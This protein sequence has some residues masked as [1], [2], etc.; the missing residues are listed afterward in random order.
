MSEPFGRFMAG[1]FAGKAALSLVRIARA[2][3][4]VFL[5]AAAALVVGPVRQARA[6]CGDYLLSHGSAQELIAK[7]HFPLEPIE[8]PCYGPSCSGREAPP[9]SAAPV[10]IRANTQDSLVA[11]TSRDVSF[12][13]P[14]SQRLDAA[15]SIELPQ[16]TSRL[17]RPPRV[18]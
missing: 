10:K 15:F 1:V 18:G 8:A 5:F 16:F 2:L 17:L 14:P 9:G 7:Q 4:V 13:E 6:T 11:V 3:A 12:V